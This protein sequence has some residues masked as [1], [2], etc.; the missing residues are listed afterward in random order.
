MKWLNIFCTKQK[1][2]C[3][4]ECGKT[5]KQVDIQRSYNTQPKSLKNAPYQLRHI[6]TWL[7]WPSACGVGV[8]IGFAFAKIFGMRGIT[9]IL[10]GPSKKP[11]WLASTN[12]S[13]RGGFTDTFDVYTNIAFAKHLLQEGLY[14]HLRLTTMT[15]LHQLF[16]GAYDDLPSSPS[17]RGYVNSFSTEVYHTLV[18]HFGSRG[19]RQLGSGHLLPLVR[20]CRLHQEQWRIRSRASAKRG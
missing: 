18:H 11:W 20:L 4:S 13:A 14:K 9:T 6:F 3:L 16:T 5:C 17:S 10:G 1:S 7:L 19:H 15:C 8:Y 2:H 12:T